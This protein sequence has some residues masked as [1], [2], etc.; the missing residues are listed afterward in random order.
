MTPALPDVNVLLALAWPNHQHHD[1]AHAWF[2][3]EHR[4]G[5]ATCALTQV[6]F[7]RLSSNPAY[8]AAAVSPAA[9]AALLAR[10]AAHEHHHFF[11]ELPPAATDAFARAA[12]HQQVTDAYLVRVAVHHASRVVTFDRPLREHAPEPDRVTVIEV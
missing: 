10:L 7:V 8:T 3:E 12:G 9:A 11:G 5:W 1:R 4:F 2:S 6:A